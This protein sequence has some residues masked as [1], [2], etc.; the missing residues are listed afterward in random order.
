METTVKSAMKERIRECHSLIF[1][2]EDQD[3]DGTNRNCD[4]DRALE[5]MNCAGR[6]KFDGWFSTERIG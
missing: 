5:I 4:A 6:R 2:V 1:N 3:E